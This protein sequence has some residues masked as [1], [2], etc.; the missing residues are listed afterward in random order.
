MRE[1]VRTVHEKGVG[2]RRRVEEE[3]GE[4]EGCVEDM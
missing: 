4:S 3:D 2:K 1:H